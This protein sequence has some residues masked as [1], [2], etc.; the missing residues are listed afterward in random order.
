LEKRG[1][2]NDLTILL[3]IKVF[4]VRIDYDLGEEFLKNY[5]ANIMN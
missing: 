1:G 3:F 5:T 4:T 2:N